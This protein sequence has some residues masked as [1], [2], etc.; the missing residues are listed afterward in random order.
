MS[1]SGSLLYS[2]GTHI[3]FIHTFAFSHSLHLARYYL[4]V[5]IRNTLVS[6]F[7]RPQHWNSAEFLVVLCFGRDRHPLERG[8]VEVGGLTAKYNAIVNTPCK[9]KSRDNIMT[10]KITETLT[11]HSLQQHSALQ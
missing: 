3:Q 9:R 7:I 11:E 2:T 6:S 8:F 10:A 4:L 5:T 1:T